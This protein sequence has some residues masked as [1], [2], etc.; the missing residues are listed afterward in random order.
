MSPFQIPLWIDL[1]IEID[2]I[3]VS[4][5]LELPDHET[6]SNRV[7]TGTTIHSRFW[8][9]AVLLSMLRLSVQA[10]QKLQIPALKS[11]FSAAN[12][13][14]SAVFRRLER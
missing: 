8:K 9:P 14:F 7:I 12:S 11:L 3:G 5:C 2:Q 4:R 13:V 1:A 10:F 6:H